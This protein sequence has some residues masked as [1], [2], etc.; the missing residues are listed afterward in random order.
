[1]DTVVLFADEVIQTRARLLRFAQRLAKN[2]RG[3]EDLVQ[4]TILRAL[5]NADQFRPGTNLN[6]W[7]YT[8]LRNL[9]FNEQ[10]REHHF[11]PLES[12][13]IA[14]RQVINGDQES[15]QELCEVARRFSQLSLVRREALLLVGANGYSYRDAAKVAGCPVGTMK[16]RV[17]RARAD[18]QEMLTRRAIPRPR[19][20][21]AAA[22]AHLDKAA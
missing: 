4:E 19:D 5:I 14:S 3:A 10:H 15:R 21:F 6:A 11:E 1:M 12:D 18:L 13:M 16:S 8:I 2:P 7:L 17:S 22:F 20:L 9:H